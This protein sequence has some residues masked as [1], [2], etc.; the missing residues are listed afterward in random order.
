[1]HGWTG[2]I[3][4]VDLNAGIARDEALPEEVAKGYVGGR[5]PRVLQVIALLFQ[6]P[7]FQRFFSSPVP[8]WPG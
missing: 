2:K 4:R 7:G 3:L 5:E 6:H 1:M 8:A